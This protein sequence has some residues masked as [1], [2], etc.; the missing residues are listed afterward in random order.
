MS[1]DVLIPKMTRLDKRKKKIK[2]PLI[3]FVVILF[4]TLLIIAATFLNLN[5]KHYILP[6]G[7]FS[8]KNLTPENFVYSFYL[9]PQIPIVMFVC[10]VLGKKMALTSV[11]LYILAGLFFIPVFA[12]G[13]GL[14]YF[15]QYSFG[16]ILA[17]LP[18]V[19]IAGNILKKKYSFPKMIKASIFGVLTIHIIGI[20]YMCIIALIKHSG[21]TFIEGWINAQ[22]GL[23]II[24]D[25]ITSFLL[26]LIGKYLNEGLKFL[27]R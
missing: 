4:G 24:Y 2:I 13:G 6:A 27:L 21:V 22:S 12:L 15:G 11:I 26:I 17:Y 19:F 9:I 25:I 18:A 10:S 3:N 7:F 1:E 8:H 16:Y 14:K 5:I 20:L 23:K